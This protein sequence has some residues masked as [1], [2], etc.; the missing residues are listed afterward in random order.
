M[1]HLQNGIADTA[2]TLHVFDFRELRGVLC[3]QSMVGQG[4]QPGTLVGNLVMQGLHVAGQQAPARA[5]MAWM[6]AVSML[7]MA[8]LLAQ[9]GAHAS[10][11]VVSSDVVPQQCGLLEQAR[12][13]RLP[14]PVSPSL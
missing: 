13:M 1:L 14:P 6:G 5:V 8:L 11:C 3:L 9:G 10:A 2:L 4:L 12:R 7:V